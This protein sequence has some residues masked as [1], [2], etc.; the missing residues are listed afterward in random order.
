MLADS[1]QYWT[2]LTVVGCAF[3]AAGW[4]LSR[5][6]LIRRI[7]QTRTLRA[8]LTD[9]SLSPRPQHAAFAHST[10][11]ALAAEDAEALVIALTAPGADEFLA[12]VWDEVGRQAVRNGEQPAALAPV[13]LEAIPA[14]VA[15]RPAGVVK[16]P[17]PRAAT[18]AHFVAIVMNHELA[19]PARPAP[20]P[21]YYY[22]TL[23]KSVT[24]EADGYR[25]VFG[26]WDE[27]VHRTF[28]PS[29]VPADA[30]AF[31]D[32]VAQ[33]LAGAD[34]APRPAPHAN[35]RPGGGHPGTGEGPAAPT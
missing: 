26:Q 32:R 17:P 2:W 3:V 33:H 13:G 11:R 10:L 23:E 4:V 24:G 28:G 29:P 19:E 20:A 7:A 31:L 22:F 27:G 35:A 30:R 14:R 6:W 16:M 8:R 1:N 12:Q 34:A 21:E 15:G 25:T 18:E 5:V 9:G